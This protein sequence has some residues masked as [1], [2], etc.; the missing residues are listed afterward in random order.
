M[1]GEVNICILYENL[2]LENTGGPL[3]HEGRSRY[4]KGEIWFCIAG[5]IIY[6]FATLFVVLVAN[7]QSN[8]IYLVSSCICIKISEKHSI[9]V[10]YHLQ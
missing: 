3:E 10:S 9:P 5:S 1:K 7:K 4:L 2:V 8:A 6:I